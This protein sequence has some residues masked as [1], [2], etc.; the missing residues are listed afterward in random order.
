MPKF[1]I[2]DP[3]PIPQN[4]ICPVTQQDSI[5]Y[6]GCEVE[7]AKFQS[8]HAG[9]RFLAYFKCAC[10]KRLVCGVMSGGKEVTHDNYE[11]FFPEPQLKE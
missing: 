7:N 10:G 9:V 11:D 2:K 4:F 1:L 8:Y 6:T 3:K 5:K